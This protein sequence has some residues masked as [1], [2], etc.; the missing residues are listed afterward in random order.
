MSVDVVKTKTNSRPRY[1][2]GERLGPKMAGK[3]DWSRAEAGWAA[4]PEVVAWME[5][6]FR[7]EDARAGKTPKEG[8]SGG[9]SRS[10]SG[11]GGG[12]G[13]K[14]AEAAA[15]LSATRRMASYAHGR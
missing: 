11:G 12:G 13:G 5:A 6:T 10:R 8:G 3:E 14:E 4:E 7:V 9:G 15:D 1:A 2:I